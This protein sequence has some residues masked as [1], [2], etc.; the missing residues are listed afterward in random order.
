VRTLLYALIA[1]DFALMV[2]S[3][4]PLWRMT[5]WVR[6]PGIGRII[7]F[8]WMSLKLWVALLLGW[9]TLVLSTPPGFLRAVQP[10]VYLAL[11]LYAG[12]QSFA[13]SV[14]LARWRGWGRWG[15]WR[16]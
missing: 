8:G 1:I 4:V 12:A 11:I 13:V 5:P 2:A 16:R 14:A 7:F 3:L 6:T 9:F 10:W 15:R